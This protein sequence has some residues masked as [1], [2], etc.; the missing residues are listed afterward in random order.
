[1]RDAISASDMKRY[2]SRKGKLPSEKF[3]N[4][5]WHAIGKAMIEVPI[6]RRYRISKHASGVCGVNAIRHLWKEIDSPNCP[7]CG[8]I[9]TAR[10]VWMCQHS[11][12]K[13]IWQMA[14]MNL[15]TALTEMQSSPTVIEQLCTGLEK[16]YQGEDL[17]A[18]TNKQLI[19][20]QCTIGWSFF[21]E[22]IIGT[23]WGIQQELYYKS[24]GSR[25]SGLRWTVA[26]IKKLWNI[27]WDLWS[28][29]N[30]LEHLNDAVKTMQK[31]QEEV[32]FSIE[33]HIVSG[34][35]DFEFMFSE[36]EVAKV[37]LGTPTYIKAWLENVRA[38]SKRLD[39]RQHSTRELV[40]MRNI[41]MR[42]LTS[43]AN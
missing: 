39:R 31:L 36:E 1:M 17:T 37:R 32:D 19:L 23:H 42:F 16:W 27:A 35:D 4:V 29:R 13:I 30:G 5:G 38:F 7:R 9:E 43:N 2:W 10:H 24:I 12:A 8:L 21:L 25:K 14:I 3:H 22:G 41:M 15:K 40:G 33:F 11:D 6:K 34:N 26:L 18:L 20:D 28:H